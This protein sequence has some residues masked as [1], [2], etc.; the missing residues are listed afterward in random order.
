LVY[1]GHGQ[2]TN[3]GEEKMGNHWVRMT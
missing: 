2:S 3:I 1:P